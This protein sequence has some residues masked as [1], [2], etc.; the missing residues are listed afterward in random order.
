MISLSL[1]L[2]N[3]QLSKVRSDRSVQNFTIFKS[4]IIKTNTNQ[5]KGKNKTLTQRLCDRRKTKVECYIV[6]N[7]L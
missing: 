7:V 6:L 4:S 5:R 1:E 2:L 3:R